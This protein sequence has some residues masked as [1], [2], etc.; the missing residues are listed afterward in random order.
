[1]NLAYIITAHKNPDQMARL[2]ERLNTEGATFFV[3]IDKGADAQIYGR[4][5]GSVRHLPNV[6]FMRRRFK[7]HYMTLFS[8]VQAVVQGIGEILDK[9]VTF[10][11]LVYVTGQDY[12]IK[13]NAQIKSF[14]EDAAG[15]S[16]MA[17]MP[18]PFEG[19][20]PTGGRI[21][22]NAARIEHWHF[23]LFN[24]YVRV[25]FRGG[26][27]WARV[28]NRLLPTKRTFPAGFKPYGGWAY[29]CLSRPHVEYVYSF[30]KL[31]PAFIRFFR[32]V[33][34]ADEVIFQTMLLNSPFKD[35][36]VNDDLR[37]V[38]WSS[39][40]CH[41]QVLR[42][43]DIGKLAGSNRLFARKFDVVVDAEILDLI[44]ERILKIAPARTGHG[45]ETR[46][47][48]APKACCST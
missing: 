19:R 30:A 12:P 18:L 31:N 45:V 7:C 27:L 47:E 20:H 32:F 22:Q 40:D 24:R 28:L 3:H 13:T 36:I 41:P 38:D 16:Y 1:M 43:D 34:S 2:I 14:L 33:K 17:S 46:K 48:A 21:V 6:H 8:A 29:W 9:K 10:D 25:P 44:D 42:K 11:Y 15:K 4:M 35:E 37:Y 39:D 26:A 23:H 5:A